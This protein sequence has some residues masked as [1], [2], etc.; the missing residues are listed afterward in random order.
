V[1][2]GFRSTGPGI[3]HRM[4]GHLGHALCSHLSHALCIER[5]MVRTPG[6]ILMRATEVKAAPH[7]GWAECK[8]Q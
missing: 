2:P 8:L 6:P 1:R 4:E 5:A 3:G 7:L